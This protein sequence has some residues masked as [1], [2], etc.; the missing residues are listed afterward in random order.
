MISKVVFIAF[1]WAYFSVTSAPRK[2]GFWS[3]MRFRRFPEVSRSLRKVAPWEG[4]AW[5]SGALEPFWRAS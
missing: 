4:R 3:F 2:L 5:A 1:L